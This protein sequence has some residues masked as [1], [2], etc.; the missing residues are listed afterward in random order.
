MPSILTVMQ[1]PSSGVGGTGDSA[2]V[3]LFRQ[4]PPVCPAGGRPL[5]L[6]TEKEQLDLLAT[7]LAAGEQ[8]AEEEN[9]D[10]RDDIG[11]PIVR[12]TTGALSAMSGAAGAYLEYS[13]NTGSGRGRG[14]GGGRGRGAGAAPRQPR[15]QIIK[16]ALRL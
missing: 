15:S 12:R 13:T 2:V 7:V 16:Q 14:R 6:S 10:I 3:Q 11:N 8:D 4:Y 9:D 1:S 5:L